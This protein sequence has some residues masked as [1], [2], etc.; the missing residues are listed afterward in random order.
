[1]YLVI[2]TILCFS[3]CYLC[4]CWEKRIYEQREINKLTKQV[5]RQIRKHAKY[6][7]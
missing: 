1:M 7:S 5:I 3:V 6:N 4:A 2:V